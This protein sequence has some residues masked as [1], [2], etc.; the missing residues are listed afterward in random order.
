MSKQKG[1]AQKFIRFS[2]IIDVK[3]S[4]PP[5]EKQ[6][7]DVKYL[8]FIFEKANKTS[9]SKIA[10]LKM[11]NEFCLNNQK[12]VVSEAN[13]NTVKQLGEICE[14]HNGKNISKA[15]LVSGEYPVVGGG[16]SPLGYHN[17][18]NV[19]ENTILISKDGAYA[20]F[21]SKYNKKVFVSGHGIYISNIKVNHNQEFIYYYLKIVLQESLY[22][23]QTGTAQPGINKAHV[24]QLKISLPTLEKQNE[25]VEYC[26]Y[27]DELIKLLEKEIENNNKQA[28]IFV[29]GVDNVEEEE[30]DEEVVE[31]HVGEEEETV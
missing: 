22:K 17:K 7:D 3:I 18:F 9:S 4:I 23:L 27:N 19:D 15:D 2:Q 6:Q 8:D 16:K 29:S 25:I 14:F 5:I 28:K 20:G 31:L 24:A 1:T 10:E 12:S 11:L 21:V 26:K 13:K 30:E